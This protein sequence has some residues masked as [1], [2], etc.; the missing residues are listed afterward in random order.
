MRRIPAW[1]MVLLAGAAMAGCT[2]P[3]DQDDGGLPA[4]PYELPGHRVVHG[5]GFDASVADPTVFALLN[6]TTTLLAV[7]QHFAQEPTLALLADGTIFYDA[8][9]FE[10]GSVPRGVQ[11]LRW[12]S[13]VLRSDDGGQS[14]TDVSARTLDGTRMPARSQD[15]FLSV[16]PVTER[17][18]LVDQYDEIQGALRQGCA[19]LGWSDDR[20]DTWTHNPKACVD[21]SLDHPSI[22]AGPSAAGTPTVGYANLV[23]LCATFDVLDSRCLRSDDGGVSFTTE[24]TVFARGADC[25]DDNGNHGK[26]VVSET[27]TVY[28]PKYVC[29]QPYVGISRDDGASWEQVAVHDAPIAWLDP[30]L[31]VGPD[32]ALHYMWIGADLL[33]YLARST[34]EGRSWSA[35]MSLAA[36]GVNATSLPAVDV[37]ADGRI[38]WAYLGTPSP[39]RRDAGGTVV[40]WENITWHP[41]VGWTDGFGNAS[42]AIVTDRAAP[43]DDVYFIGDCTDYRCGILREFIDAE[44][45]PD[46]T[47]YAAFADGCLEPCTETMDGGPDFDVPDGRLVVVTRTT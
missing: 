33:P 15:T 7:E 28:L 31:A 16:D 14:W 27:G 4:S 6:A 41:Y 10:P 11:G 1:L 43:L 21:T 9:G 18:F 38:G 26:V 46:G 8:F 36:T 35:P 40:S 30:S 32:G 22:A 39:V 44:F 13:L 12:T 17:L 5:T 19:W 45:G 2:A 24:S 3:A 37:A 29:G 47:F 34:D 20:G 42:S 25:P 23:Y